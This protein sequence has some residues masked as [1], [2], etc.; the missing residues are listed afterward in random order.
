MN[1]IEEK[2]KKTRCFTVP[3][4]IY[5]YIQT[6]ALENSIKPNQRLFDITVRAIQIH[7]Q[8]VCAY[9]NLTNISTH[10]FRKFFAM[11]IYNSNDYNVELV[12]QLLKHSSVAITQHYLSVDSKLVENALSKHVVL[13]I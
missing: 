8:N 6:Y 7:L 5:T 2:T 9:L 4:E 11:S 12:R 10:S 13:P 1:I 3:N